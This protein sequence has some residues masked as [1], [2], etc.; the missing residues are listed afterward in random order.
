MSSAHIESMELGIETGNLVAD[1]FE[2]ILPS[3]RFNRKQ[4]TDFESKWMN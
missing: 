4:Y 1:E 3:S 2:P